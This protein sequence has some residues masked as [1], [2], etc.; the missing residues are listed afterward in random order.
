MVSTNPRNINV[1]SVL[2]INQVN[3]GNH[4]TF[5]LDNEVF[6]M[7]RP[8]RIYSLSPSGING[9]S[10]E[11]LRVLQRIDGD[12][13]AEIEYFVDRFRIDQFK[14]ATTQH[15]I[16]HNPRDETHFKNNDIYLRQFEK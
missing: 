10:R 13:T 2:R 4:S 14:S 12:T 7:G 8:G 6:T 16:S 9:D 5:Q 1:G 11:V 3:L 15:R